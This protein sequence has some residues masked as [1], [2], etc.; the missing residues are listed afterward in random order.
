M[1]YKIQKC[2]GYVKAYLEN[3]PSV[4]GIGTNETDAVRDLQKSIRLEESRIK[5]E[6]ALRE[7]KKRI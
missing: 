5:A 1:N 2:Q 4:Y 7:L 3:N 6:K